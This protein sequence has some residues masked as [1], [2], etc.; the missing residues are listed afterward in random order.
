MSKLNQDVLCLVLKELSSCK[1][2][3]WTREPLYSCL[4]VNKLWCETAVPIIWS[5]P[6]KFIKDYGRLFDLIISFLSRDTRFLLNNQGIDLFPTQHEHHLFD[7]LSYCRYMNFDCIEKSIRV[8]LDSSRYKKIEESRLRCIELEIYIMIVSKCSA[9][10]SLDVMNLRPQIK[11][12]IIGATT[13]LG[14]LR[15]LYCNLISDPTFFDLLANTCRTLEM[16]HIVCP[17]YC[18]LRNLGLA[19]LIEVQNGLKW[20]VFVQHQA[21]A[22]RQEIGDA[23]IKQ[24]NSLINFELTYLR[25]ISL[26]SNILSSFNNLQIL[27][28]FEFFM[29]D[30]ISYDVAINLIKKTEGNLSKILLYNTFNDELA[31]E[32][33][34]ENL[35]MKCHRLRKIFIQGLTIA[36][37]FDDLEAFFENWRG[38]EPIILNFYVELCH[39]LNFEKLISVFEKYEEEGV[40]KRYDALEDYGYFIELLQN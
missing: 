5:N 23:L 14:G 25:K 22:F 27:K 39:K 10:K 3:S 9:V 12:H 18:K 7:Y 13:F 35:L 17:S 26:P 31:G 20:F 38:R 4:F 6:W 34:L 37:I 33:L 8:G 28:I 19:R 40:L 30:T 11:H 15:S 24:A 2:Q 21:E 16:I 29:L 36:N 32:Y 1:S